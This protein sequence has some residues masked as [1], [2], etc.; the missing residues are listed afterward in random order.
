[1]DFAGQAPAV[2]RRH[3]AVE[4]AV[5]D[6]DRTGDILRNA[7]ERERGSLA[8][9]LVKRCALAAN[10]KGL[11]RQIRHPVPALTP[12]VG[13][14]QGQ[15][16]PDALVECGRARRIITAETDTS[17]TDAGYIKITPGLDVIDHGL[18]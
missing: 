14:S 17:E 7:F 11:A 10:P 8:A 13:A 12:V 3:D 15:T 16:G 1:M 4:L 18:R 5:H 9:R 6:V 2:G